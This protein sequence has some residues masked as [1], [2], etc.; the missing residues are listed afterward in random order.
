MT[1]LDIRQGDWQSLGTL[2]GDIRRIVFIEEQAVPE[3]EEW[4]GRDPNCVH[5]LAY[6]GG[7]AIGT[8]R[9]LP[10]GHIGRVAVLKEG[11]GL[12]IGLKLMQAAIDCA[13]AKGHRE[14]LLDAQ[15]HALAFYRRLGFQV[16]GGEF[17]DAGILH[18]SM[19]LTLSE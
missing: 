2:A 7:R 4:D 10:D 11:R 13:R 14:V 15:T 18:R 1:A 8:A 19:R 12:G 6:R 9:L 3:N 16:Y 17:L 5:F